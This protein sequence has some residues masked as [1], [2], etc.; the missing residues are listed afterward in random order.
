LLIERNIISMDIAK[1]IDHTLLRPDAGEADIGALCA[2]A[3]QYGFHSVCVNSHFVEKAGTMLK[4]SGVRVTTVVGFPLGMTLTEVKVYEALHAALLG[5]EEL[6]VV[7]NIGAL[8]SG[9]WDLVKKDI[10]DVIAATKGLVHKVIIETCYLGEEEKKKAA[11]TAL[12]AGAG[13]VKTSTGFGP[14]GATA[15]DVRLIRGVLRRRAG[16]KASGG[17][18]TLAEAREMINAGAT[19]IGT[20]HGRAIMEELRL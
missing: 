4:G 20:S 8:K 12:E 18:R 11:T 2:E 10:S 3:M 17:I 14:G 7:I 15:E 13:F 1:L 19:R 5:V 9:R 6:D 16:V